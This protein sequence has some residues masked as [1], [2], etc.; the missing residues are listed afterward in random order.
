MSTLISNY[1][2][3]ISF[4]QKN[5]SISEANI[6]LGKYTIGVGFVSSSSF[7]GR[8][9]DPGTDREVSMIAIGY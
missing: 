1:T 2:F 9:A 4:S 8:V 6:G 7:R 5:L 3:P